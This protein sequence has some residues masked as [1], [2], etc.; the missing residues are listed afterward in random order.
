MTQAKLCSPALCKFV[1]VQC[2][3]QWVWRKHRATCA[4]EHAAVQ[5]D[6]DMKG[7]AMITRYLRNDHLIDVFSQGNR[8]SHHSPSASLCLT[9]E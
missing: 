6:L 2:S 3:Q 5:R 9:L 4:S 8:G 7:T 1:I